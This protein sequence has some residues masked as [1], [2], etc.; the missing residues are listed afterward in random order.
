MPD[1][2]PMASSARLRELAT[3]S[4]SATRTGIVP[5]DAASITA[6]LKSLSELRDLCQRL[7]RATR[8]V[9]RDNPPP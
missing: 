3:L 8:I 1:L 6:R 5:M 4:A 9:S 2:S 7:G